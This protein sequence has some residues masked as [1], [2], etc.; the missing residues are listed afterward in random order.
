MFD[1]TVNNDIPIDLQEIERSHQKTF[2][3]IRK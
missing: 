3:I 2:E 1:N